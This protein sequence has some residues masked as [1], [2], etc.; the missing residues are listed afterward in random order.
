MLLPSEKGTGDG[1]EVEGPLDLNYQKEEVR[2]VAD[3]TLMERGMPGS[4]TRE[5]QGILQ[6]YPADLKEV[7]AG[8]PQPEENM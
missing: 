7:A 6:A 5:K 3:Q 4:V 8:R 1:S 2:P